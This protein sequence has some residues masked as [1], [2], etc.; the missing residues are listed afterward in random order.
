M[1]TARQADPH[2]QVRI[3]IGLLAADL[4]AVVREHADPAIRSH[5]PDVAV[6]A[7]LAEAKGSTVSHDQTV[8]CTPAPLL[9]RPRR[10]RP[11]SHHEQARPDAGVG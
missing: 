3:G 8:G 10:V 9:L 2:A 6:G 4:D 5:H 7:T 1:P 11:P